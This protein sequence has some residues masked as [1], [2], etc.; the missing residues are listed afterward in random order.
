MQNGEKRVNPRTV[1]WVSE[2]GSTKWNA[3]FER[4]LNDLSICQTKA[5]FDHTHTHRGF[6]AQ[7]YAPPSG[8]ANIYALSHSR[9]E[10][11]SQQ[12]SPFIDKSV[13]VYIS[14]SLHR[15]HARNSEIINESATNPG[16]AR[17]RVCFLHSLGLFL[18]G[19][20]GWKQAPR[21]ILRQ[22]GERAKLPPLWSPK[23]RRSDRVMTSEFC[24]GT[25]SS[26]AAAF[27]R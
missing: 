27:T 22:S 18:F 20:L 8:R 1:P 14:F 16:A 21:V 19:Q 5:A 10:F 2:C 13:S 6:R 3:F 11:R 9:A 26:S 17:V 7:T 12:L 24:P 4:R 23:F 15:L 25:C